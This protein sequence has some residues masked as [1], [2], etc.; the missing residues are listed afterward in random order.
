V[1]EI[2]QA[3]ARRDYLMA[4]L[5]LARVFQPD[6]CQ[7]DNYQRKVDLWIEEAKAFIGSTDTTPEN[8]E[9]FIQF[10]YVELAFSGDEKNYFSYQYSLL[11]Y[12]SF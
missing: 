12:V 7:P 9:R 4:S 5:Q 6:V 11:D 2:Q 1:K 8:F 10:F 3:I